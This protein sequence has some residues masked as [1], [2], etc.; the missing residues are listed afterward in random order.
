MAFAKKID[1]Y[2]F[3]TLLLVL[4][5]AN[6]NILSTSDLIW[7]SVVGFMFLTAVF[8]KVIKIDD[9]KFIA[10]FSGIYLAF[11]FIR[12]PLINGLDSS[13]LLSDIVFLFK[14]VILVYLYCLIL[15]NNA[16]AY[17]VRV[18]THLTIISFFFFA[19]QLASGEVIYKLSTAIGLPS[20]NQIPGYTNFI[21]FTFVKD[22]HDYSNSGFAWEPAAFGCFLIIALLLNLSLDK[23]KF[24]KKSYILIA[25]IITTFATTDYLALLILYHINFCCCNCDRTNFR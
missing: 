3:I 25:G 21:I 16:A 12:D 2:Y 8:K 15:K 23:F 9:I 20:P 24:E 5:S 17:I 10:I 14:F 19:L 1:I 6:A 11:V 22:F 4:I 7:F 13:F 18:I